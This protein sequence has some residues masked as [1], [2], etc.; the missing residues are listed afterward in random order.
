MNKKFLSDLLL[1]G[2]NFITTNDE[3]GFYPRYK[4]II[5]MIKDRARNHIIVDNISYIEE[6]YEI[7]NRKHP[8]IFCMVPLHSLISRDI[9]IDSG[10]FSYISRAKNVQKLLRN[11]VANRQNLVFFNIGAYSGQINSVLYT[12]TNVFSH[13]E[14]FLKM[15]KCRKWGKDEVFDLSQISRSLKIK[16]ILTNINV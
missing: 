9:D 5:N 15:E 12:A 2:V 11:A 13:F 6:L 8:H 7:C 1:D 16:K 3:F 4:E 14:N 10:N